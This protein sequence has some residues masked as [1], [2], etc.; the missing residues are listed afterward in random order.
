MFDYV[1]FI[2][3]KE[4]DFSASF[5]IRYN[6]FRPVATAGFADAVSHINL[7]DGEV[8]EQISDLRRIV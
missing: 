3:I 2:V 5:L 4:A 7:F 1:L 8:F 6:H